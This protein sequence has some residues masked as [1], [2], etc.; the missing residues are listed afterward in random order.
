MYPAVNGKNILNT[1]QFLLNDANCAAI[2]E[3]AEHVNCGNMVYLMLSNTVGGAVLF[4]N[5]NVIMTAGNELEAVDM[6]RGDNWRSAEFG[7]MVIHP[8]GRTC[9]CGKKDVWMRIVRH[10]GLQIL[11]KENWR[12]F[13]KSLKREMQSM[14][15]YGMN[16][17][18]I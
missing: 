14:K 13:L 1:R 11:Q 17:W 15:K 12:Y 5:S 8:G 18:I 3:S 2:A 9:Y 4:E 6:Y 10:S 7:H 16:I